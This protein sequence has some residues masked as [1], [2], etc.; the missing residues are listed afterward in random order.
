[1][2]PPSIGELTERVV[3]KR[4]TRG[5]SDGQGGYGADTET[6]LLTVWAKVFVVGS[7]IREKAGADREER[8]HDVTI[9]YSTTPAINDKLTWGSVDLRVVGIVPLGRDWVVLECAPWVV[10]M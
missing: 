8:T 5:T 1:M 6:T 3:L 7:S 4:I 10:A 2:K 9:R